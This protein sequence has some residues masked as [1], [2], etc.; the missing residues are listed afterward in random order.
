MNI[1]LRPQWDVGPPGGARVDTTALLALLAGV[2]ET[3]SLAQA[4]R[5]VGQSYRHAW[6]LVKHAEAL[7]GARA[8]RLRPRPR[9]DADRAGAQ[10]DLGRPAHRG[11]AVAA[12][13]VAGL[14]TRSATSTAACRRRVRRCASTPATASPS[15]GCSSRCTP[16]QLPVEL[17][18]RNSLESVA[19]L[20]RGDC[21][22]AGLHVPIGEFEA[23][24]LRRYLRWLRADTHCLVHVAV[25]TQGLFVAPRQPEEACAAWP[26]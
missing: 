20:A 14:G 6:G 4:A 23:H 7:F 12:A 9:L 13:G 18:Y 15:R 19:A 1:T 10:A 5:G 22:L 8:D 3:G 21:D 25:R 26:T 11:A 16:P 24:A 2:Q 17:R